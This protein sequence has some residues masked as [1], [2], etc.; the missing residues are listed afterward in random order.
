MKTA[1]KTLWICCP[2]AVAA[3]SDSGAPVKV[4]AAIAF[5]WSISAIAWLEVIRR[6][7]EQ[8]EQRRLNRCRSIARMADKGAMH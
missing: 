8:K 7:S 2:F 1:M 6:K 5:A 3:A 4:L